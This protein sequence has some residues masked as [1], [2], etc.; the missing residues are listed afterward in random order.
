MLTDEWLATFTFRDIV[1]VLCRYVG[2]GCHISGSTPDTMIRS[3]EIPTGTGSG[4]EMSV[5]TME[6]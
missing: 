1:G 2:D 6:L 5:D 3:Q 4:E